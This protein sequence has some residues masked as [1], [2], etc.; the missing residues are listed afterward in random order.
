MFL[1]GA[2][3]WRI[4]EIT[5]DRVLVLSGAGRA[6]QDAVLARRRAPGA[7]LE[8][9]RAIG[10]LARA[11]AGRGPKR[12]ACA[13]LTQEHGLDD[14]RRRA[15]C[16]PTSRTRPRPARCRA[17][18]RSSSSG[19]WTSSATGASA[20]CRRSE[21]GAR[22]VG[23]GH[24]GVLRA[25]SEAER[26]GRCG[27]TTASCSASR[28]PRAA[29]ARGAA[30]RPGRDRG[31]GR[32]ASSGTRR[33]SPPASVRTRPGRCCCRGG[34][35]A[36]A[37]RCGRSASARP[38]CW[39]WRRDTGRSRSSSRRIASAC[40]T[41]STCR[42]WSSCCA[43]SSRAH[44]RGAR[45]QRH[46]VAVRVVAAVR[47][48][49][50]L[51][52][53]G[54]RAAGRARAQALAVDPAQLRELLGEAELREL[55][56][57]EALD[58]LELELQRL[59]PSATPATPTAPRP[60]APPRRPRRRSRR[61]RVARGGGACAGLARG[62]RSG[63]AHRVLQVAGERA[64]VAAGGRRPAAGRARLAPPPG[65]R[66]RS[67]SRCATR[68]AT[69]CPATRAR[70]GPSPPRRRRAAR[71]GRGPVDGGA[72][73]LPQRALGRG[74]VPAGR[75]GPRVVR[76][77]GAAPRA[78]ALAGAAAPRG[79]AGEARGA[80]PLLPA[81]QG[82]DRPARGPRRAVEVIEQLQ[83]AALLASAL[84]TE[85]LPARLERYDPAEL[86]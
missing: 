10:E 38:T 72:R 17:T 78:S 80:R 26:R 1:L 7:P 56:D 25:A 15:T 65:C 84:E 34:V 22:A 24:R 52:L 20:C 27:P 2:S 51:H 83:G 36:S 13:R 74:R 39:R 62:A 28:R 44:P 16:W 66:R 32:R 70:T 29:A 40:A 73:A 63:A 81:W 42:R 35:R 30:S 49:R 82:V 60:A 76:R 5:H 64:L 33:S 57:A 53:R 6:G 59:R 79:G 18:G 68:S 12:E 67:S 58:E 8:F 11:A 4:E 19:T 3:S 47:L 86:D 37:R 77:G 71:R 50:Q 9:G 69:S 31:P 55:L 54:R 85:I 41:C 45:R 14:A 21:P 23:H 46:A 48:R 61:A 75:P 43:T